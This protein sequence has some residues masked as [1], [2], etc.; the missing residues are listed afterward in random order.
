[1]EKKAAMEMSVGTLVTIVLLM[2]VLGLGIFLIQKIFTGATDSVDVINDKVMG[3]INDLFSSQNA[4]VVVKLGADRKAKIKRGSIDFG[5]AIGAKTNSG[6]PVISRNQLQYTLELDT[7]EAG[8]CIALLGSDGGNIVKGWINQKSVIGGPGE[9]DKQGFDEYE[10][11]KAYAIV[12]FDI[13]DAVTKCSQ[14]IY[15]SV[16]E[17][18]EAVGGTFFKIQIT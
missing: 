8:N 10:A 5:I 11:D 16:T 7:S 12:Y 18:T 1:M 15:V 6:G 14:K 3:Q 4:R 13:P 9:N 17:G 2:A